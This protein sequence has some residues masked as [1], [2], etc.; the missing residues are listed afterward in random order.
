MCRRCRALIANGCILQ[1]NG[2]RR[3]FRRY[4]P[5]A[6]CLLIYLWMPVCMHVPRCARDPPPHIMSITGLSTCKEAPNPHFDPTSSRLCP[7]MVSTL[8]LHQVSSPKANPHSRGEI[9]GLLFILFSPR[10]K[11]IR[12]T[13][14]PAPPRHPPHPP[15]PGRAAPPPSGFAPTPAPAD[16]K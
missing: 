13:P 1:R 16:R 8:H 2:F 4:M 11:L 10:T 9:G 6:N 14:R 3:R 5:R 15:P 12:A 7:D